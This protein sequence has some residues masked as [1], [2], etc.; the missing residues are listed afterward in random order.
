MTHDC[1]ALLISKCHD[2][3]SLLIAATV[4]SRGKLVGIDLFDDYFS[5]SSDSRLFRYR[6]W[7][8]EILSGCAYCLC[9]TEAMAGVAQCFKPGIP[10][11]VVNDP[12]NDHDIEETL[13]AADRKAEEARTRKVIEVAWFGVGDNPYFNVGITDLY[14]HSSVLKQLT[15]GGMAVELTVLTNR[16]ALQADAL[17]LI[18]RLPVPSKVIE[19][20]EEAEREVLGRSLIA[21]LPVA[22]QDF[23]TAKS[24]NR[25]FSSLSQGCQILSAGYPLYESLDPLVYRDAELLLADLASGCLRFSSAQADCYRQRLETYGT[26]RSEAARVVDFMAS[27]HIPPRRDERRLCVIHGMSTRAEVHHLARSV[28]ALSVGSPYCS[29]KLDFDLSFQEPIGAE[30]SG[31]TFSIRPTL[32][33]SVAGRQGENLPLPYELGTYASCMESIT[34]ILEQR[35]G[36]IRAIIS[37]T[38][39]APVSTLRR[40]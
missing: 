27:L 7:L 39:R 38:S 19:W 33:E 18:A 9:S 30:P 8:A 1:D 35:F 13:F 31:D 22:A 15:L 23:S 40:R 4:S 32:S 24:L 29:A 2:A 12:A 28:G 11:L 6:D 3:R 21:F 36:P 14:R 25:A 20:S 10:T 5:Q 26:G 17:E 34:K 16:R 37:E